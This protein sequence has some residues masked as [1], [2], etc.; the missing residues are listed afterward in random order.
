MYTVEAEGIMV[1][2]SLFENSSLQFWW[3]SE[4]LFTIHTRSWR[5]NCTHCPGMRSVLI[6]KKKN[7]TMFLIPLV[8]DYRH[9]VPRY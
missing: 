8:K 4:D 6:K 3:F 5:N 1:L 9:I 7:S 2:Q